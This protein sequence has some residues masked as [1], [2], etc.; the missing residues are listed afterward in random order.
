MTII[1]NPIYDVVFKFMMEDNKV[2][3]ILLSALLKKEIVELEMRPQEFTS[4]Q[5]QDLSLFRIDFSA[6]VRDTD[7][8]EKLIVIELQKA[9]L[10]S[11]V[12]R[13]RQYLG[14]QYMNK[15]NLVKEPEMIYGMPI[16]SVYLLGHPLV[17]LTEPVIYVRRR[18]LDYDDH[19]ISESDRFIE[20]LTHD[21]II[22]QIPYL[23][24]RMR[25][26]LER[27]LNVF[28]QDNRYCT[29]DHLLEIDEDRFTGDEQIVV[30]RLLKAAVAPDI[31]RQ[32]DI[33]D[34]LIYEL[35]F[36]DKIIEENKQTIEEN[37]QMIRSMIGILCRNGISIDEIGRQL[38]LSSEEVRKLL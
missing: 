27:L 12:C 33:E 36:R 18:Y 8:S 30:T 7:G 19:V 25:N 20:S 26:R 9:W 6:R 38:S 11:E 28:D 16:V 32:M 3:K 13:F 1:A 34:E 21:S 35:E 17:E 29:D 37:K 22:V 23:K 14:L 4:S 5:K 31:R 24:G 15:D 2:A 10:P